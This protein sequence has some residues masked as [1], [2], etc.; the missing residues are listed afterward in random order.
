MDL[1]SKF[2]GVVKEIKAISFKVI[3]IYLLDNSREIEISRER[4]PQVYVLCTYVEFIK[5][6]LLR[7]YRDIFPPI[8]QF[9]SFKRQ[10]TCINIQK[11]W[12][13]PK[14]SR[15]QPWNLCERVCSEQL[16]LQCDQSSAL[17][18]KDKERCSNNKVQIGGARCAPGS[19]YWVSVLVLASQVLLTVVIQCHFGTFGGCATCHPA[20][21]EKG[22]C[23]FTDQV[24]FTSTGSLRH[25]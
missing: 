12:S 22:Q 2:V 24:S 15:N 21:L 7:C 19:G 10:N 4:L 18:S 3:L 17:C 1:H 9:S 16:F 11:L 6:P 14:S 20:S 23:V 25:L 13:S 8:S 5:D